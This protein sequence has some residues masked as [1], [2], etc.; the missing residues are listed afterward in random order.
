MTMADAELAN[1]LDA[2]IHCYVMHRTYDCL[3]A[4]G[5]VMKLLKLFVTLCGLA[6]RYSSVAIHGLVMCIGAVQ[7]W[8]SVVLPLRSLLSRHP[9]SRPGLGFDVG[10]HICMSAVFVPPSRCQMCTRQRGS[11]LHLGFICARLKH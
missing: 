5:D 11:I 3:L 1:L 6:K 4:E 8:F 9:V 10:N 7:R 2:S